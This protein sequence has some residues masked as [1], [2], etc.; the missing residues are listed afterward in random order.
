MIG[1][2]YPPYNFGGDGIYMY[3][4][5]N[6]LAKRG[7]R[8]DVL[9]CIDAYE[10]LD[11]Q[12]PEGGF[13]NHENVTVHSLKSH[14]GFFSPLLTQQTGLSCIKRKKIKALISE[15]NYDVIH[16]HNM[17]LIGLDTLG[18]GE[19]VKLYTMHEYWLVC[20]MHVLLKYGRAVCKKQNCV[21]CQIVGKRPVQWWR[22]CGLLKKYLSHIDM[23]ISPSLFAKQKHQE[24]GMNEPIVHFPNF[25]PMSPIGF[26]LPTEGNPHPRNQSYFLFVG[27]LEKLKGVQNIISVF[28]K[29]QQSDLLVAGDGA[30]APILRK[31]ADGAP[32][33]HFL[34]RLPYPKLQVLYKHTHALIVSSICLENCPLV[35]IEAFSQRTPVIVNNL[36]GLPEIVQQSGGGCVYSTEEELLRHL[37]AIRLNPQLRDELGDKGYHMYQDRLTEEKHIHRYCQLVK[38]V[39]AKKCLNNPAIDAL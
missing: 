20:P 5:S 32:N 19:A 9:H 10:A 37:D 31:L 7:H 6:E 22:Y 30:Y 14:A 29:Y 34:G 21:R 8:V 1:T 28:R 25:M 17:S 4:L 2:F 12:G 13:E 16:Y 3:R 33:I 23:Y 26:Q 18:L 39:A 24:L 27:R 15:N 36:G 35:I 11:K 38:R